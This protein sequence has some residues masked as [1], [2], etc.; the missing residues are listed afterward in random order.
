MDEIRQIFQLDDKDAK[1][2]SAL[3]KTKRAT[4]NVLMKHTNIER[5]TIYDILERL[6][7]KGYARY[8]YENNV[9]TYF[10]TDKDILLESL[11]KKVEDFKGLMP[12]FDTF[13]TKDSHVELFN[14]IEGIRMVFDEIVSSKAIHYAFGDVSKFV[15]QAGFDTQRFLS[16]LEKIDAQEKIIY[17]KGNKALR[18]RKGEYRFLRRDLVPPTP[19]IICGKVTFLFMFSNPILIIRID[20]AEISDS[21][22]SYFETYWKIAEK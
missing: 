20:N 11:Q 14:G 3:I 22:M 17:P 12:Q 13:D 7:Q 1:I 5:R 8:V 19:V 4:V 6:I 9:K 21:Y 15:E 18:I 2:F 10:P 16:R